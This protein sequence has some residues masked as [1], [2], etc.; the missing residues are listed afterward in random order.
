MPS[1][2]S[3]VRRRKTAALALMTATMVP[4]LAQIPALATSPSVASTDLQHVVDGLVATLGD[5]VPGLSD[6][7]LR[8]RVLPTAAQRS[9][10]DRLGAVTLR[11]NDFGTP[12]SLLPADGALARAT[13]EDPVA[14]AR[15]YLEDNAA[16]FGLTRSAMAGLE[17]VN[18]Q[19][20][21][22]YPD[23]KGR[24]TAPAGHAVLFRQRF[25]DLSPALGSMVTVGV[26]RGEIAYVS[27]SLV[28]TTQAAPAATL[29]PLEG[30]VEAAGNVGRSITDSTLKKIGTVVDRAV[31]SVA[32]WTRLSVPGF[33]E[34]QQVR[35]RALA[36]ADGTVRPVYEANVVDNQDGL[37]FA[38]TLMVDAVTGDVLHRAHQVEND[39]VN[40]VYQGTFSNTEC[41]PKHPFELTDDLTTTFTAA[42]LAL[43]VDDVVVK[44]F[45]PK[46]QL[47]YTG[48]LLTSPEVVTWTPPEP[49]K[50]GVYSAQVCPFDG[51]S[52][53]VGAYGLLVSTSDTGAPGGGGVGFDPTWSYFPANPSISPC[54]T[55][56]PNAPSPKVPER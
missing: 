34:Q 54:I 45:G 5:T 12:A 42:A 52:A 44:F 10:A 23:A 29:T 22:D 4:G 55:R 43:P 17:L 46:D 3:R 14:A 32:P 6:L 56:S 13:S 15:A 20:L 19:K 7:D 50:A 41:G 11:W 39:Q 16:L 21:A 47:L 9:A 26:S 1:T 48:D 37:A 2:P 30:W 49:L 18:E 27:S 40:E 33:S 8:G 38:Y 51:A 53:V 31:G 35:L 28:R 24:P 25:G 36:M